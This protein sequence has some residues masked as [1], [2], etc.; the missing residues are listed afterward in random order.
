MEQ[1]ASQSDFERE[2]ATY[3]E[4][5]ASLHSTATDHSASVDSLDSAMS[6]LQQ[7][8]AAMGDLTEQ[9]DDL[10]ARMGDVADGFDAFDDSRQRLARVSAE[11]SDT[12]ASARPDED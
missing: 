4:T 9:I 2:I 1:D 6:D 11:L 12:A 8:V 10:T 7:S 5:M 3:R